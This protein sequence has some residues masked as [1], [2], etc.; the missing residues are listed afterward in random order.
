MYGDPDE[1]TR[2]HLRKQPYYLM[3]ILGTQNVEILSLEKSYQPLYFKDNWKIFN[4]G[5][6][7]FNMIN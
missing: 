2:Y 1:Y 4:T 3:K 7:N 5:A 6:T